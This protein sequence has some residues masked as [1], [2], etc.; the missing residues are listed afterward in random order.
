MHLTDLIHQ[1]PVVVPA[2]SRLVIPTTVR[3]TATF[4]DCRFHGAIHAILHKLS[5]AGHA[6]HTATHTAAHAHKPSRLAKLMS[7]KWTQEIALVVAMAGF[8]CVLDQGIDHLLP[9]KHEVAE[10]ASH[11]AE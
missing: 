11:A 2:V 10:V 9:E 7:G 1:L 8:G 4:L 5:H 6:A 3:L